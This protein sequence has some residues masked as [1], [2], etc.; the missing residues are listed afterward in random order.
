M[1]KRTVTTIEMSQIVILKRPDG[2]VV[3]WCPACLEDVELVTPEQV[4]LLTGVS[5]RD[6]CH[7]VDTNDIHVVETVNGGLICLK[8]LLKRSSDAAAESTELEKED[9]NQ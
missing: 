6:I 3:G 7:R 8:S 9:E 1:R 2:A 5:L 4:S